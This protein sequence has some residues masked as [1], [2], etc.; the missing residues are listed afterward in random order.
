[1][2]QIKLEI[3]ERR[4]QLKPQKYESYNYMSKKQ[5]ETYQD[6]IIQRYGNY[7][8][9][10]KRQEIETEIKNFPT[11]MNPRPDDFTGECYQIFK[12]E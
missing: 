9:T 7:K 8:Q 3:K 10:Q 11:E 6:G 12:V 1:M 4:L 5:H 2:T